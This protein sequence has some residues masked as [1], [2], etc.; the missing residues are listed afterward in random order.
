REDN[1]RII[2]ATESIALPAPEDINPKHD[3][4]AVVVVEDSN[5]EEKTQIQPAQPVKTQ[6]EKTSTKEQ[7]TKS[8]ISSKPPTDAQLNAIRNMAKRK[9]YNEELIEIFVANIET[10]TDASKII[11]SF[12][13]GDFSSIDTFIAE[14]VEIP[15]EPF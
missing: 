11:T 8:T 1:K 4:D 9:G 2:L 7:S 10:S 12:G 5:G 3:P 13:K 15:E 14:E 6:Q